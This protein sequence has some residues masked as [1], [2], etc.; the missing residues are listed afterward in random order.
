MDIPED[1]VFK[2]SGLASLT[3]L[4]TPAYKKIFFALESEQTLFSKIEEKFL[5][6]G[7][8]WP[9]NPLYDFSRVW[10]YPYVFHHLTD[11]L[12]TVS[13]KRQP[14]VADV[15]SGVTFFPFALAKNGYNIICTDIDPICQRDLNL[16]IECVSHS[17]GKVDFRLMTNENLPFKNSE[18]DALYCISVLEHI[19]DFEK[20]IIEMYRILKPGGLCL[21]TCDI[22]LVPNDDGRQLDIENFNKL[23]SLL[24]KSF[25][26]LY[27]ESTIHP[28][29]ILTT[30]NSPYPR[31]SSALGYA[32]WMFRMV[33]CKLSKNKRC[34][35]IQPVTPNVG[36]LGLVLKRRI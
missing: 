32:K 12:K 4:N 16:A 36:V 10:E 21:I 1:I 11:Y 6:K 17:P 15:G 3:E 34:A 23:M 13:Q 2:K 35:N 30:L 20:T 7:Y 14:I 27:P 25:V 22:N 8:K 28:A 19:K 31:K 5:S 24:S 26:L 18:C 33:R 9:R 29:D